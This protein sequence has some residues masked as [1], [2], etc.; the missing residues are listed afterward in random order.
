MTTTQVLLLILGAFII[1]TYVKKSLVNRSVKH[2]EP[3]EAAEK[4]K[5]SKNVILL[6]VRTAAE[7]KQQHIKG[8]FHIPL[9]EINTRANE[10][11][12]FKDKEIICYCR[13]GNRS[14]T[15]AAKLKKKGFNSANMRG[16]IIRWNFN[17]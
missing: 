5:T 12:K 15:A 4:V 3:D 6:D 10:L 17:R 9:Q 1:Y 13:S 8:S 16:G 14:V 7:R 11:D 2:Y